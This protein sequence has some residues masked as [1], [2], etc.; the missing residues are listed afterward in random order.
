M[1]CIITRASIDISGKWVNFQFRVKAISQR[2]GITRHHVT[3]L[4]SEETA[5]LKKKL[6]EQVQFWLTRSVSNSRL[7]S[8][9]REIP[10]VAAL[11]RPSQQVLRKTPSGRSEKEKCPMCFF[12]CAVETPRSAVY[13]GCGP[14]GKLKRLCVR[15]GSHWRGSRFI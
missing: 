10:A 9:T 5:A 12:L 3:L 13:L 14:L 1:D 8:E 4:M 6:F 11:Q 2:E 15:S 7:R